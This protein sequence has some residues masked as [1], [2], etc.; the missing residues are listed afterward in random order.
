MVAIRFG[1][2]GW[3]AIIGDDF[4]FANVR[5]CAEALARDL[6]ATGASGRGVVVGYDTRF[7]SD[8]F[9]AAVAEVLAAHDVH[10]WLCDRAAPTPAISYNVVRLSAGAGVVITASHNPASWNGFKVKSSQ[11]GSSPPEDVARLEEQI[12]A[13]LADKA[14]VPRVV[15][16]KATSDGIV[17]PFDPNGPY[18]EQLGR[19]VDLGPI[20]SADLLVVTDAMYG[21]GGGLMPRLFAGSAVRVVEINGRAN[22][23]FPG[24]AQPEPVAANLGRLTRAVPEIGA[25]IGLALDGDAD[26]LGVVDEAGRYMTTL[27]V[28]SLLAHHLLGRRGIR[29]P[30]CCTITMSAMVDKLGALYGVPVHRTSVGFKYVGPKMLE[31]G[32]I[33]GGEESGGYALRGHVPERDGMLSAL[34]F[35]DAMVAS[36]KKPSE[37]L[38]E[39]HDAVGPHTFNRLDLEFPESKREDISAGIAS[40]EPAELAGLAVETIDRRDGVRFVLAGGWWAVA[41]LSGTEPLVRL[42]AEAENTRQLEAL[43][44]ALRELLKV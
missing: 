21:A 13:V 41:R 7:G 15:L 16:D 27:E 25:A 26:R 29:A 39:L 32:S 34:L 28:F 5:V 17:E 1:T 37:L 36:G 33:L 22:P 40:V 18:L 24:I 35:M 42:Y 12:V 38:A 2:D 31:T 10:V 8:R 11:G 30:I 4:T 9:A 14:D 43:L 19:L 6:S 3:R 23:A 44:Q 20:L